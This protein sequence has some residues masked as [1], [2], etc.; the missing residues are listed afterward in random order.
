MNINA[1]LHEQCKIVTAY[2]PGAGGSG[3]QYISMKNFKRCAI[4]LV[5]D[6]ATTVTGTDVTL[7][8]AT[9]IA[10]TGEKALAFTKMWANLDT[11]AGDTLT[12]TAVAANTFTSVTTDA[13][14]GLYVMEIADTDLDVAGGF[15]CIRPDF[16]A[17]S[18]SVIAAIFVLYG[19]KHTAD[20]PPSAVID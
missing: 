14:N 3:E 19:A 18:A 5:C 16:T 13:K 11:A 20:Q 4:I 2:P 15:D 8:Q 6:N 9:A 12:E 10:G 7:K 1:Y 17:A